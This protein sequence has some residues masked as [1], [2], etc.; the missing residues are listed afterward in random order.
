MKTDAHLR[1]AN[2][3]QLEFPGSLCMNSSCRQSGQ[4]EGG[5]ATFIRNSILRIRENDEI[6]RAANELENCA[7]SVYP[8]RN[9]EDH[10]IAAGLYRPPAGTNPPNAP[11]LKRMLRENLANGTSTII[12]G[13]LNSSSREKGRNAWVDAEFL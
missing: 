11:A 9:L 6:T 2:I 7:T 12:A 1:E 10:L 4:T 3:D 8:N 13:D 5:A